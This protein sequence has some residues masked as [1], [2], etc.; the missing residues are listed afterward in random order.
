MRGVV[1]K[2]WG[3]NTLFAGS[4]PSFSPNESL[5]MPAQ[6]WAFWFWRVNQIRATANLTFDGAPMIANDTVIERKQRTDDLSMVLTEAQIVQNQVRYRAGSGGFTSSWDFI[7]MHSPFVLAQSEQWTNMI[8]LSA[9]QI[10][11]LS[12]YRL[13]TF[14]QVG[15][16]PSSASIILA[17]RDE[18]LES[19][20]VE[21][22]YF[23]QIA[24][25][26]DPGKPWGG[27]LLIE[28]ASYYTWSDN[29]FPLYDAETGLLVL[30]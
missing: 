17:G 20:G 1:L 30:Q 8:F 2:A 12:S 25:Y 14:P 19:I 22:N 7:L 26:E 27:T 16:V 23:R 18:Y 11:D 10:D 15:F 13:R 6:E 5:T 29:A 4:P 28:P 21:A 24:L 3:G 9:F